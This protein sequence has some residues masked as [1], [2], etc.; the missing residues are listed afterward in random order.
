MS[1]HRVVIAC[2]TAVLLV[3]GAIAGVRPFGG[4]SD[5]RGSPLRAAGRT[6]SLAAFACPATA[7]RAAQPPRDGGYSH[8]RPGLWTPL[9]PRGVL[10]ISTSVPPPP[11]TAPGRVHPDGS[12][13]TKFPWFG[14][15]LATERLVITGRRI[16]GP[17]RRLRQ[18]GRSGPGGARAR[19][20]PHFWP[21][22]LRFPSPGCWRV[23]ARSGR[24][25]RTFTISVERARA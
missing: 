3:S 22:Y 13:S 2:T 11:G 8:R 25:R 23:S 1:A 16:D 19:G 4:G 5:L 24:A 12:L 20:W 6:A 21:G 7:P 17:A 10:R 18:T 15:L 14:S 9:P